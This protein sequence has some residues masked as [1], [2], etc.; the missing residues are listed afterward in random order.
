MGA[1]KEVRGRRKPAGGAEAAKVARGCCQ[2]A[3]SRGYLA[4]PHLTHSRHM[5]DICLR[6]ILLVLF[7]GELQEL[8]LLE[9]SRRC[10][11]N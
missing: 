1:G 3:G 4:A 8:Y 7:L 6:C 2:A 5:S 9:M 11:S 10:F